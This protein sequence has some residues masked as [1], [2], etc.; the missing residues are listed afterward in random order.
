MDMSGKCFWTSGNDLSNC[1]W[2]DLGTLN[3]LNSTLNN[4]DSTI[5][6]FTTNKI[7]DD[8][9]NSIEI[10]TSPE[11]TEY[12]EGENFD[13]KGMVVTAKYN[14]DTSAILG[15]SSYNITNGTNLAIGQ[16]SVTI[17]YEDKSTTQT[18][19]VIK[20]SVTELKITTPPKK[21]SYIE[22]ENFD[23]TEMVVTATYMDG[24]TKTITDY[25][26]TDGKNLKK[27]QTQ[28]TISYDEKT[29]TQA[30]TVTPNQLVELKVSNA[31]NKINY[32][33]GQNFDKTGM[34]I[35]GIY[36][37]G[38]SK[39][40]TNYTIENGTN[41]TKTQTSVTIKY[42][43][44]T[45]TQAIT[46]E[47]KQITGISI[48]NKPSKL[49]YIQNKENL[50]LTGGSLKVTYNDGTSEDITLTS[51]E[52]KVTNFDNSKLGKNTITVTYKEK[53][54]QFDVEIIEEEKA[55]NSNLDNA[56]CEVKKVQAYYFTSNSKNDYVLV[57]VEIN[58]ISRNTNNDSVEY[59]YYLSSNSNENNIT[60]WTKITEEQTS[61]NKLQFTVDTRNISNYNEIVNEDVLYIYVKEVAI[62]GGDQSVAI[63]KTMEL[64][65]DS[66]FETFV[67]N[68]KTDITVSNSDKVTD[69]TTATGEL[70]QTGTKITLFIVIIILLNI[71]II[72]YIKN[73]IL[74][75]YVK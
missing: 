23:T 43:E 42:D 45:V 13:K 31:P 63:T 70:P 44:K 38:T 21:I 56:N 67:D 60:N 73:K 1:E 61:N 71:V 3:T 4:A 25:T 39:E 62:K 8:S 24:T 32:V 2:I 57:N 35:T 28:V 47:E 58:Q 30:I 14:N 66:D 10:T 5:K 68:V 18:I 36:K 51:N 46:V 11:K 16:T 55:E 15:D 48:N 26:I 27:N 6:A 29:I 69:S 7:V 41:L 53:T 40:I 33:V 22:G 74:N 34:I 50:D 19:S 9:L 20:N 65:S 17:T 75:K 54:T 12:F 59:Y 49:T 72:L 64:E 37:D 52:V